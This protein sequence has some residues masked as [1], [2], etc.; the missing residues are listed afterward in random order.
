MLKGGF[1]RWVPVLI[2]NVS[3][4]E[5]LRGGGGENSSLCICY[6]TLLCLVVVMLFRVVFMHMERT[7]NH[8]LG[9]CVC[10][11]VFPCIDCILF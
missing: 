2:R 1:P 8:V 11:C 3:L 7:W 5:E 6:M 10:V 4:V 9:V